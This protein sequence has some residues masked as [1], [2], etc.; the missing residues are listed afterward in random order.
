V[1]PWL[2]AIDRRISRRLNPHQEPSPMLDAPVAHAARGFFNPFEL[3]PWE[4]IGSVL[5]DVLDLADLH[6]IR[7]TVQAVIQALDRSVDEA[8]PLNEQLAE[9]NRRIAQLSPIATKA[10]AAPPTP[11]PKTRPTAQPRPIKNHTP[12]PTPAKS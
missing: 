10:P 4:V 12:P 9:I 11:P 1:T 3:D 6:A 8:T 7:P 5:P 2:V